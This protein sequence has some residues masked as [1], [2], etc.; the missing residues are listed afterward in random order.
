MKP[1]SKPKQDLHMIKVETSIAKEKILVVFYRS[2][3]VE[4]KEA[5]NFRL[6]L[7]YVSMPPSVELRLWGSV[8]AGDH[9]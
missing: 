3:I 9:L 1:R 6:S 7:K 8:A 4:I 5:K 2:V